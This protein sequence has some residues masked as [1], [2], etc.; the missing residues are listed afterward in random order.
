VKKRRAANIMHEV[1]FWP[2]QCHVLKEAAVLVRN[3]HADMQ[4]MPYDRACERFIQ[5]AA[6][7][8]KTTDLP[9]SY[10]DRIITTLKAVETPETR[11]VL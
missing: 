3:L 10:W 8:L 11:A 5:V 7:W 9:V 1:Y 4:R 6:T 2:K